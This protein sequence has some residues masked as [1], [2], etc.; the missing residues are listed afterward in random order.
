MPQP[1]INYRARAS[2]ESRAHAHCHDE[3]YRRSIETRIPWAID[4]LD[5][6]NPVHV[7]TFINYV[8]GYFAKDADQMVRVKPTL[9]AQTFTRGR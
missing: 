2:I 5:C 6:S 7:A 8:V 9:K 1:T 3:G 4:P